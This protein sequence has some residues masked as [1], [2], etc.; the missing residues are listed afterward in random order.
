MLS[1]FVILT[2]NVLL[3]RGWMTTSM[4]LRPGLLTM[5]TTK[6][7]KCLFY[8]KNTSPQLPLSLMNGEALSRE[9]TVKYLG[10]NFNWNLTWS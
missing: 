2:A 4:V 3:K 6:C 1:C 8:S 5:D 7:V 9:Q 10:V